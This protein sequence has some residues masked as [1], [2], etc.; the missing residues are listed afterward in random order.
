MASTPTDESTSRPGG[1]P[2]SAPHD[3]RRYAHLAYDRC[4]ISLQICR[5]K[6]DKPNEPDPCQTSANTETEGVPNKIPNDCNMAITAVAD[7]IPNDCDMSTEW[8]PNEI[9][10]DHRTY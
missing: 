9:E 1:E 2:A 6:D 5:R 4:P 10:Y 3:L 7:E 8:S